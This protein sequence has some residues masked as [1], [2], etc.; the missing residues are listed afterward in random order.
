MWTWMTSNLR[1]NRSSQN[2]PGITLKISD[3]LKPRVARRTND[4]DTNDPGA[5][6][7][8]AFAG[9]AGSALET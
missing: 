5:K 9:S 1:W 6:A 2:T 8:S 3:A 7:E 4:Q